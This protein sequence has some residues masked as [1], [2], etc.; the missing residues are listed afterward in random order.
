M[1]QYKNEQGITAMKFTAPATVYCHLG[2]NYYRASV[3]CEMELADRIVDFIDLEDYFKK[4]LNGKSLTTE[5]LVGE[6]FATL[7]REYA[8]K[9]LTVTV[10][11]D[12]HFPIDTIK[13]KN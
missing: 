2:A 5:E 8:P 3:T 10:H 12:S 7:E 4:E 11:S 1:R 13:T 9:T 6:V